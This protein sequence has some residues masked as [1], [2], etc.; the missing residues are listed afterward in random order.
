MPATPEA[1]ALAR[2]AAATAADKLGTDIVGL[3][4]SA[5]L[6]LTDIF[7]IVSASNERQ[8]RAIVDAIEES[9]LKEHGVKRVRREGSGEGHWILIDFDDIVV[10]VFTEEDRQFYAL[11]RLWSDCPVVDLALAPAAVGTDAS[12]A[13][14]D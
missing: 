13:G 7:V 4:V 11:E 8:V 6:A 9:L 5:Q 14:E 1:T 3:D 2:T 10:H 12:A